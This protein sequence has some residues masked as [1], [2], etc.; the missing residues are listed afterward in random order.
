MSSQSI[1]SL[2][3]HTPNRPNLFPLVL[4]ESSSSSQQ[5]I[6]FA[7]QI[8]QTFQ[9]CSSAQ[10]NV[11]NVVK[12]G[13]RYQSSQGSNIDSQSTFSIPLSAGLPLPSSHIPYF[14]YKLVALSTMIIPDPILQAP[15]PPPDPSTPPPSIS[16]RQLGQILS[17]FIQ[18]DEP[19][20][21]ATFL[22]SPRAKTLLDANI[23]MLLPPITFQNAKKPHP[24]TPHIRPELYHATRISIQQGT[25]RLPISYLIL[26]QK[27]QMLN[28]LFRSTF[29]DTTISFGPQYISY[30]GNIK[31]MWDIHIASIEHHFVNAAIM[32]GNVE[33]LRIL[34]DSGVN[35][36]SLGYD[37]NTMSM[38]TISHA[39]CNYNEF[40]E[41]LEFVLK[42]IYLPTKS[43]FLLNQIPLG[44]QQFDKNL[45]G[46]DYRQNFRDTFLT[47]PKSTQTLTAP[48]YIPLSDLI[49]APNGLTPMQFAISTYNPKLIHLLTAFGD[50]SASKLFSNKNYQISLKNFCKEIFRHESSKSQHSFWKI[51]NF[52]SVLHQNESNLLHSI[53][54]VFIRGFSPLHCAQLYN[55]PALLLDLTIERIWSS[56]RVKLNKGYLL[57]KKINTNQFTAFNILATLSQSKQCTLNMFRFVFLALHDKVFKHPT[58][59][60]SINNVLS[61]LQDIYYQIENLNQ[62]I[63]DKI[64]SNQLAPFPK[65]TDHKTQ[66]SYLH[67]NL[68]NVSCNSIHSPTSLTS[69]QNPIINKNEISEFLSH[70]K[71]HPSYL[72]DDSD[73]DDYGFEMLD[74]NDEG[75]EGDEDD[76]AFQFTNKNLITYPKP[77][78][79][80]EMNQNVNNVMNSSRA[81]MID[82][83]FLQTQFGEFREFW[84]QTAMDL[85]FP[86]A[87]FENPDTITAK[88][89]HFFKSNP[90]SSFF[91][92]LL[93]RALGQNDPL[94]TPDDANP[95]LHRSKYPGPFKF[96][97][98]FFDYQYS[99]PCSTCSA[100]EFALLI[101]ILIKQYGANQTLDTILPFTYDEAP[102]SWLDIALYVKK[103]KLAKVLFHHAKKKQTQTNLSRHATLYKFDPNDPQ[104]V[105]KLHTHIQTSYYNYSPFNSTHVSTLDHPLPRPKYSL[106]F[107]P[108]NNLIQQGQLSKLTIPHPTNFTKIDYLCGPLE[109]LIQVNQGIVDPSDGIIP[110]M[111]EFFCWALVEL[112]WDQDAN[113]QLTVGIDHGETHSAPQ[114]TI[115]HHKE[116]LHS[117][118]PFDIPFF[119][120][121][122]P[123]VHHLPSTGSHLSSLSHTKEGNNISILANNDRKFELDA[124]LEYFELTR[125]EKNTQNDPKHQQVQTR[126]RTTDPPLLVNQITF[127]RTTDSGSTP[128]PFSPH[129]ISAQSPYSTCTLEP[130]PDK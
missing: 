43:A 82:A 113:G 121:Q 32:T 115:K 30:N 74:L 11:T 95:L 128:T 35:I 51:S 31:F 23:P 127:C 63:Q 19:G 42:E 107:E 7:P 68:I 26:T 8:S 46:L 126:E 123:L 124:Q 94:P 130:T 21:L 61:V 70:K 39:L 104:P 20:R 58:I 125:E 15:S 89:Q 64:N 25:V 91:L 12:A 55:K 90:R 78:N 114:N 87:F 92:H 56:W 109:Y 53:N 76:E 18:A 102:C 79:L 112:I 22:T 57:S 50:T 62:N 66:F 52:A 100:D 48:E 34:L 1:F 122:S 47:R 106:V 98:A 28:M 29:I 99:P 16:P 17:K 2:E 81:T 3:L 80:A 65:K 75:D 118:N 120:E 41:M 44:K 14:Q 60:E 101:D 13:T 33:T 72:H 84:V 40:P 5:S 129:T 9:I 85:I 54:P 10:Y 88:K 69:S 111:L 71:Y 73:A 45:S 97:A 117:V 24:F 38:G 27:N 67:H 77:R 6:P 119:S 59:R 86:L 108:R 4:P 83:K 37:V 105:L 116:T 36:P 49:I 93:I 96:D 103:T 110:D